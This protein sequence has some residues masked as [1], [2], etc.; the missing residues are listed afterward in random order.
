MECSCDVYPFAIDESEQ[1]EIYT[2]KTTKARKIHKCTECKR[3]ILP[4]EKYELFKGKWEGDFQTYKTCKDCLS[5]RGQ[6]FSNGWIFSNLW[7]DLNESFNDW[8]Y[9]VPEDCIS[10][11]TKAARDKVCDIIEEGWKFKEAQADNIY[12][13][14]A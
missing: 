3:E 4:G 12:N 7:S 2:Q 1:A 9:E 11:L 10:A 14:S 13:T 6:F 8:D 5:V